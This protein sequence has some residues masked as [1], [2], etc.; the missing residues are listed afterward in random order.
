MIF[1]QKLGD[2]NTLSKIQKGV[3]IKPMDKLLWIR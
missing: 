2:F 3:L 1:D